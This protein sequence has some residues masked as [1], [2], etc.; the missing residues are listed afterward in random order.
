MHLLITHPSGQMEDRN[1]HFLC[2]THKPKHV[3][4][5]HKSCIHI[6]YVYINLSYTVTHFTPTP[7]PLL[8]L[9]SPFMH[10]L[11]FISLYFELLFFLVYLVFLLSHGHQ[12]HTFTE[13]QTSKNSMDK[14]TTSLVSSGSV[15]STV[16][17]RSFCRYFSALSGSDWAFSSNL[18]NQNTLMV[19]MTCTQLG[20]QLQKTN[21][22][23]QQMQSRNNPT[24][25]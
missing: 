7:I 24:A 13:N 12:R 10:F 23:W 17:E 22:R 11:L 1:L 20:P 18:A 9:I 16:N 5:S 3:Q 25:Q 8:L 6:F 21:T 4:H 14:S 2:I 15:W 19:N